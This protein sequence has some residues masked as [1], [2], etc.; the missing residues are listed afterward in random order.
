MN[1]HIHT[2]NQSINHYK[3]I[4]KGFSKKLLLSLKPLL[5]NRS[6]ALVGVV[7]SDS[8]NIT[9]SSPFRCHCCYLCS[10]SISQLTHITHY[11][12]SSFAPI[13]L[14]YMYILEV[15]HKALLE[16]SLIY[17]LVLCHCLFLYVRVGLNCSY[18]H[19]MKMD[20]GFIPEHVGSVF[21]RFRRPGLQS[22]SHSSSVISFVCTCA[23]EIQACLNRKKKNCTSLQRCCS[24]GL[25]GILTSSKVLIIY[26]CAFVITSLCE[27]T[28]TTIYFYDVL[29][30]LQLK[31]QELTALY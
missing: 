26:C 1:T 7:V 18:W 22:Q 3:V 8:L 17:F 29:S 30:L 10:T 23:N 28:V 4:G 31:I 5:N 24:V 15:L 19:Q 12:H 20:E 25:N 9:R 13:F 14:Y 11:T 2:V 16:F 21:T 6:R 27:E